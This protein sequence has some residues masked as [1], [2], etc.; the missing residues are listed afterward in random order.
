MTQFDRSGTWRSPNT[1][2]PHAGAGSSYE[3]QHIGRYRVEK[4]LGEGGFGQVYLAHDEKLDRPVAPET[5][6]K[7]FN[8]SH[9][10]A[11]TAQAAIIEFFGDDPDGLGTRVVV[12]VSSVC[13]SG[14]R[15]LR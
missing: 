8:L 11:T 5:Q 10:A 1:T 15:S 13:G 2:S 4:L 6:L 14:R 7:M 9:A 3:P 12:T